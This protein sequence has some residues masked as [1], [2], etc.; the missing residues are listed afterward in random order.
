[1]SGTLRGSKVGISAAAM[2]A[3]FMAYLDISIVNVALAD[4]R[5][6]FGTPIAQIGWV[7]T[8]YMM[9]N[10]VVIPMTGWLQRRF[11][12]RRYFAFSVL[13]FTVASALCGLAW[14][15][16]ALVMFRVLQ[17]LGGGAII[18]TS[19]AM[20]L[21][22]FPRSE[23]GTATV[24]FGLG[25]VSGPLLG[26]L[27][28]GFITTYASWP[29]VFLINVPFGLLVA[30]LAW[31]HIEEPGYVRPREP[32]DVFGFA[33]L[34]IGMP[35]LQYVLEEGQRAGWWA[36]REIVVVATAS[37][38]ALI[39]FVVRELETENPIVDLRIF[40]NR[41]Y[42]AGTALNFLLGMCLFSAL[43]LFSLY[44][45]IAM[46]YTA[47]DTGLVFLVPNA[48]QLVMMIL[49]ARFAKTNLRSF[50][51]LGVAV[52]AVSFWMNGHLTSEAG[53]WNLAEP[54]MVRALATAFV[55][56]PL[57]LLAL[58][59]LPPMQI[60]VA[61]GLF[62]LTREL[63]GSIGTAWMSN[64]V[65]TRTQVHGVRLAEHVTAYDAA[66]AM[67]YEALRRGGV[68]R[69][70]DPSGAALEVLDRRVK[71]QALV[72]A[73]NDAFVTLSLVFAASIVLVL[74]MKARR[75]ES[76]GSHAVVVKGP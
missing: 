70:F 29:L 26:P 37:A 57:A 48:M 65:E 21:A 13:L 35:G 10:I 71:L 45:G 15:F 49:V 20:L 44:C 47:V 42:A 36:S 27:V 5:A 28:G 39:T 67:Q 40:R 51:A 41:T 33:L 53:Y 50:L 43:Y 24:V 54:Q 30:F 3:A 62:N 18:P 14:S 64:V 16:P 74:L 7:S 22:R 69:V 1:M 72:S 38:I 68:G 11:G 6:T 60:G 25:A 32:I 23:H 19:Q 66:A 9:A 63:G 61:T 55:Y 4:I 73:F 2:I 31:R 17:G 12:Y 46:R 52:L 56:I 34:A 59:D 76:P 8:G 58:S 75:E